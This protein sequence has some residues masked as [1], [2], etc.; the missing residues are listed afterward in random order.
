MLETMG[1]Q[2][3]DVQILVVED[4]ITQAECLK[5]LLEENGFRVTLASEGRDALAMLD[6]FKPTIVITDVVMPGMNGYELCREIKGRESTKDIPVLLLTNLSD[7][8]DVIRGLECGADNF[9][10]KPYDNRFLISRIHY[11]LLNRDI[12]RISNTEMAIEIFFGGKKQVI[13]SNR[14]QILD[15]LLSTF[16]NAIQKNKE[17]QES[18]RELRRANE[19]IKRL[20]GLIPICAKCKKIRDDN[21]YWKQ[22]EEYLREAANAEFTHG[23]CPEC[24]KSLYPDFWDTKVKEDR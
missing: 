24:M 21:G 4:S 9:I 23:F 11:M 22:I 18:N 13:T 5:Y 10:T 16:E 2:K 17:L 6:N 7:P 20:E 8:E 3:K 15:L 19:K 1:T 12:R 14:I